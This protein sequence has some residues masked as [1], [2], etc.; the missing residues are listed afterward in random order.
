MRLED[1]LKSV[2]QKTPFIIGRLMAAQNWSAF[3]KRYANGKKILQLIAQL[4]LLWLMCVEST[5]PFFHSTG[6]MPESAC[7]N[8]LIEGYFI[9]E[10]QVSSGLFFLGYLIALLINIH[11]Y[12]G[13]IPVQICLHGLW[14]RHHRLYKQ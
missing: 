2:G 3:E 7:D 6:K 12:F 14:A 13:Y 1:Y 5:R 9:Q 11:R 8:E 4:H 10:E